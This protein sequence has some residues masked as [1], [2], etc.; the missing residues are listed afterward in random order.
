[1]KKFI[2][3]W[4]WGVAFFLFTLIFEIW[5]KNIFL[6]RNFSLL[7]KNKEIQDNHSQLTNDSKTNLSNKDD[8]HNN[9]NNHHQALNKSDSSSNSKFELSQSKALSFQ[10]ASSSKLSGKWKERNIKK[11]KEEI[12][13]KDINSLFLSLISL[14]SPNL[15]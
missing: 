13:E 5:K 2:S 7:K 10:N 15:Y 8:H 11:K 6:I 4:S 14:I 12:N 1:M 3:Y 9:N